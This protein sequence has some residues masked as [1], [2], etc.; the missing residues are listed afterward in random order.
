MEFVFVGAILSGLLI[1]QVPLEQ[2]PRHHIE[3]ANEFLRR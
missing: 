1:A 2:E 3:F